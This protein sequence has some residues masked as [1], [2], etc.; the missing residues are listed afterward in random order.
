MIIL[1]RDNTALNRNVEYQP[2]NNQGRDNRNGLQ[3]PYQPERI[4]AD[5]RANYAGQS[6]LEERPNPYID[7]GWPD[8]IYQRRADYRRLYEDR[9]P[10]DDR[11]PTSAKLVI[12][13]KTGKSMVRS[14]IT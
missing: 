7:R 4:L 9:A 8:P 1:Y 6:S 10:D 11:T 2:N 14:T 13:L 3:T 12:I 5:S